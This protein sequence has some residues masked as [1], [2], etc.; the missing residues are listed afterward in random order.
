MS[1]LE[2]DRDW[3]GVQAPRRMDVHGE[4]Y[5]AAVQRLRQRE[6]GGASWG[7]VGLIA[8]C[9]AALGLGGH[10]LHEVLGDLG[11]ALILTGDHVHTAAANTAAAEAASQSHLD[12]LSGEGTL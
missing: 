7:E 6:I 8:E 11:P 9:A 1:G 4:D 5:D 12:R 3:V 2:I 10:Y